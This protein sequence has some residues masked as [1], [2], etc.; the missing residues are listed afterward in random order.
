MSDTQTS[1]NYYEIVKLPNS[2][3]S[4]RAKVALEDFIQAVKKG[5]DV[6]EKAQLYQAYQDERLKRLNFIKTKYGQR[7]S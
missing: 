4:Q 1:P 6:T 7:A 5:E 3:L 2:E